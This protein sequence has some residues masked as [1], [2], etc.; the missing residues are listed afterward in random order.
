[1]NIEFSLSFEGFHALYAVISLVMALMTTVF[2][3]EFLRSEPHRL[4]YGTF[5]ALTMAATGLPR[6]RPEPA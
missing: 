3:F 6:I 2:S 4:R 5:V 1:M